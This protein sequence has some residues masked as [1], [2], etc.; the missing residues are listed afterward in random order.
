MGDRRRAVA[1]VDAPALT[2]RVRSDWSEWSA[3]HE[4]Q[5][6]AAN[7][8]ATQAAI[9]TPIYPREIA[10]RIADDYA[11]VAFPDWRLLKVESGALLR[12]L[13][14][15]QPE[16]KQREIK[17]RAEIMTLIRRNLPGHIA[18]LV[19]DLETIYGL[20]STAQESAAFMVGYAMGRKAER[21]YVDSNRGVLRTRRTAAPRLQD[22]GTASR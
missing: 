3:E 2:P 7:V 22:G 19:S 10:E 18:A 17:Q 16:M 6:I 14:R 8:A 15:D 1:L 9:D 12:Q 21:V 20:I 4:R 13:I 5:R 11:K